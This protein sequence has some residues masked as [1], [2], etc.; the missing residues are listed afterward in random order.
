ME[1]IAFNVVILLIF[2]L[3]SQAFKGKKNANDKGVKLR[4]SS[5][6]EK[7]ENISKN[8]HSNTLLTPDLPEVKNNVDVTLDRY[9]IEFFYHMTHID[10]LDSI[11]KFGLFCNTDSY[12]KKLNKQTMSN[13][14]VVE[15]R[16]N[17]RD[18]I[19]NKKIN[20]Y[21]PLYINPKNPMLF[22]KRG[23]Q[24]NLVIIAYDKN[25][26]KIDGA[27]FTDGNA[28]SKSTKFFSNIEELREINWN[29]IR[30]KY[31]NDYI[32][33]KRIRCAE[34]LV[35]EVIDKKMIKKIYCNNDKTFQMAKNIVGYQDAYKVVKNTTL[36]FN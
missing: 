1:Y 21:V 33:G 16:S 25:L 22:V 36:F 3:I 12:A 20:S 30:S 29:C 18:S 6:I 14:N 4:T 35:P 9:G 2:W 28:A 23:M 7:A 17:K 27:V 19:Y 32:D 10:N 5:E 13:E 8:N 11:L 31:W 26:V 15:I 24:N 34:L